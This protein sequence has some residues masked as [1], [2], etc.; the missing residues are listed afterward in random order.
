MFTTPE[1]QTEHFLGKTGIP[2]ALFPVLA[3]MSSLGQC[4][5][6]CTPRERRE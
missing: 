3:G 6:V 5:W 4:Y 2:Q 1:A